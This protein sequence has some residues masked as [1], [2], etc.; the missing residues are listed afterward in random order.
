MLRKK[1]R[2]QKM[3]LWWAVTSIA[4]NLFRRKKSEIALD[5]G[6][7]S[8]GWWWW[9]S[10]RRDGHLARTESANLKG[11]DFSA[12]AKKNGM[13]FFFSIEREKNE[14]RSRVISF[15]RAGRVS[16]ILQSAISWW[17]ASQREMVVWR[18]GDLRQ[19]EVNSGWTRGRVR[20]NT[21]VVGKKR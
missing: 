7:V 15:H 19:R 20:A 3:G 10:L 9:L 14:V 8:V 12:R 2:I 17:F 1:G 21:E 18:D 4:A 11:D 16:S 13:R 6:A 5:C